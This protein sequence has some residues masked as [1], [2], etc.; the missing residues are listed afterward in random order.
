[1]YEARQFYKERRGVRGI[2]SVADER[3]GVKRW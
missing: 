2:Y 1:M 3:Q